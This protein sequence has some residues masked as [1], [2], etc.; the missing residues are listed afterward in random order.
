MMSLQHEN[1]RLQLEKLEAEFK[2]AQKA[3]EDLSGEVEACKAQLKL[4]AA[5]YE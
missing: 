1:S 4:S 2:Q 5:E 3:K